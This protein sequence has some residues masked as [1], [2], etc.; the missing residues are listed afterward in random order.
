[1]HDYVLSASV[2][3][4]SLTQWVEKIEWI[5]ESS[6]YREKSVFGWRSNKKK[7]RTHPV[8]ATH[9]TVHNNAREE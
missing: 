8:W 7:Y 3:L 5:Q 4:H 1:M 6:I 2:R 9:A